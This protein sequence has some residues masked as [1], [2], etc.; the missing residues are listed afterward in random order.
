MKTMEFSLATTHKQDPTNKGGEYNYLNMIPN[1]RQRL[2]AAF[3]WESYKK[4]T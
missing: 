4:T 2:T 3:N 1:Y